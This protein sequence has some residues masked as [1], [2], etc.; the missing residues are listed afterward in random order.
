MVTPLN[1]WSWSS[2]PDTATDQFRYRILNM[3]GPKKKH[4]PS[5]QRNLESG[6]HS[7]VIKSLL[8]FKEDENL[9]LATTSDLTGAGSTGDFTTASAEV[10]HR[11]LRKKKSEALQSMMLDSSNLKTATTVS[12][13]AKIGLEEETAIQQIE[14]IMSQDGTRSVMQ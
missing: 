12:S 1:E 10:R 9:A 6:R 13:I 8:R 4:F 11:R 5:I 14:Y 2:K 7:D 3:E